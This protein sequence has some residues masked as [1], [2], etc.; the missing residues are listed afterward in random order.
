QL[1]NRIFYKQHV[2]MKRILLIKS[3]NKKM[4]ICIVSNR[5]SKESK[6]YSLEILLQILILCL[7]NQI[8]MIDNLA[9][10]RLKP[11]IKPFILRNYLP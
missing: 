3:T 2:P 9:L 6:S 7:N 5:S 11:I 4:N 8:K 1:Y 10:L